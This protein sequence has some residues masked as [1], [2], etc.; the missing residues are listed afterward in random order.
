MSRMSELHIEIES[1]LADGDTPR[2]IATSLEIPVEW[3]V[4]VE[5]SFYTGYMPTA[6]DYADAD[7]TAYG[8][9]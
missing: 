6:D 8:A 9:M 7:A 1:R 3:V 2:Q 5:D 4:A